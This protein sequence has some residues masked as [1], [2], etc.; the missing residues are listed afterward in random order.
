MSDGVLVPD[1]FLVAEDEDIAIVDASGRLLELAAR[2]YAERGGDA[3]GAFIEAFVPVESL[4]ATLEHEPVAH[5]LGG[6]QAAGVMQVV[7]LDESPADCPHLVLRDGTLSVVVNPPSADPR[8][9]TQP[10]ATA[11][12]RSAYADVAAGEAVDVPGRSGVP[13]PVQL[14]QATL[15]RCGNDF[16][17]DLEAAMNRALAADPPPDLELIEVVIAVA[18]RHGADGAK[19]AWLVEDA[20]VCS[21]STLSNR[22]RE[23]EDC[24]YIEREAIHDGRRGRPRKRVLPGPAAGELGAGVLAD[25]DSAA[26]TDGGRDA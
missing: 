4:D 8:Y 21:R 14:R 9:A 19:L 2:R 5:H 10:A 11:D 26:V 12:I 3:Q 20:D 7:P 6:M 1:S 25:Q 23:F 24:E 18:A 17:D 13:T 22:L 15:D 16:A